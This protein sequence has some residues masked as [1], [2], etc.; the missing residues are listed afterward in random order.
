MSKK[1]F[2]FKFST[3]K[4]PHYAYGGSTR[5]A[6]NRAFNLIRIPHYSPRGTNDPSDQQL[7]VGEQMTIKIKRLS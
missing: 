5:I 7:N 6:T 1:C 4:E 3:E 2:E